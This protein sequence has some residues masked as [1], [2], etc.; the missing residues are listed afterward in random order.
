MF[1]WWTI[2]VALVLG[3]GAMYAI[4]AANKVPNAPRVKSTGSYEVLITDRIRDITVGDAQTYANLT[5]FPLIAGSSASLDYL[6]L[7][8]AMKRGI[9]VVN[10]KDRG[11]VNEV[12]IRNES[13]ERIFIMDGEEIVGA[14]QNRVLN[15]SVMIAPDQVAHVPVSCVEHG[16]WTDTTAHFESGGTQLFARARQ[17]N[18]PAVTRNYSSKAPA[19]AGQSDQSMIWDK[20]AEKRASLSVGAPSGPMHEA[21]DKYHGDIGSY[22]SH[23]QVVK[24][25]VGAI[26]AI[27]GQIIGA[28]IFDQHG[29]LDKLFPKLVKSYALDAI[30][31]TDRARFPSPSRDEARRFLRLV[32]GSEVS[33][34]DYKSPGEGRDVRISSRSINGASL[35]DTHPVHIALFAPEKPIP[36]PVVRP[37]GVPRFVPGN[38]SPPSERRNRR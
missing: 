19:M 25:Q 32:L 24:G 28:D 29:T 7:D 14:K 13:S 31:K 1:K 9:V 16:R 26:F 33:F 17:A 27:R 20:V 11:D 6:T 30:E 35:V 4:S 2:P 3:S 22:L 37:D 8:E 38:I 21:Y 34:R 15:S 10:E 23:F 5:V 12:V 18:A 36:R